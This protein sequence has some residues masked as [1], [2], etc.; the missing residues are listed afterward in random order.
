MPLITARREVEMMKA[1]IAHI[2]RLR[3]RFVIVCGDL[4]NAYPAGPTSKLQAQQVH[5]KSV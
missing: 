1:A 4:V 5:V 2:N 3:P